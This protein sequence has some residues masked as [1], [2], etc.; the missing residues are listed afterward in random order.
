M[1]PGIG[2]VVPLMAD[3]EGSAKRDGIIAS[4]A[5][6]SVSATLATWDTIFTVPLFDE[7]MR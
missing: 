4:S 1:P 2:D 3:F 7:F 5:R 6:L